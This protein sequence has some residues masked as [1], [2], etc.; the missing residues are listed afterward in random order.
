M[1]SHPY[2]AIW[3]TP[4]SSAIIRLDDLT[5]GIS[6]GA[7][8]PTK[9]RRLDAVLAGFLKSE[10]SLPYGLRKVHEGE[11]SFVEQVIV[12]ALV[13]DPYQIVLGGSRIGHNSIDLAEDERGFIPRILKAQRKWFHWVFHSLS[14]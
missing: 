9:R 3:T 11:L 1:L 13:D 6:R 12:P 14:K 4:E 8:D 10:N 5:S 2:P 7:S